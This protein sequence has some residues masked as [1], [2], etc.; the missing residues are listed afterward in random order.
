MLADGR[1][2]HTGASG[3][4]SHAE[5]VVEDESEHGSSSGMGERFD[6]IQNG[7]DISTAAYKLLRICRSRMGGALSESTNETQLVARRYFEAWTSRH[8]STAG[9]TLAEGF[10]FTSGGM[11][12]EGRDAFLD[13]NAFPSD[14]TTEMVAEAYQGEVGFQM[15]DATRAEQTVRIVEQLTVH[16]GFIV[17]STFVTDMTSFTAFLS[18]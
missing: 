18:G 5:L 4:L 17:S 10:R 14:A 3:Q 9:L 15:Y 8:P 13:L 7:L 11:T 1:L 16:N 12:I 2:F 6:G